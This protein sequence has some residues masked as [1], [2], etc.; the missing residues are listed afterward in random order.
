MI[1][2]LEA[3]IIYQKNG[4]LVVDKPFNIP[5]SGRSLDDDDCLQYWLMQRH[6]TMVWAV[7][8]LDADTSGVNLFVT[9][10]RL[11]SIYKKALEDHNSVKEYLAIVHGNPTWNQCEEFGAIGKIDQ[12]SLGITPDGKSA[13]SQFTVTKKGP[14]HSLVTVNIFT[15]RTHQ[16]RI[17]LSHLGHPIVGEEWYCNP[18]CNR[19]PRQA[20]HCHMVHLPQMEQTFIAPLATD[21]KR[22]ADELQL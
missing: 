19:H 11:V 15:G 14:E 6:G 4:L 18:P 12:R 21:L 16:I 7:H 3:R 13:H 1:D 20:L 17:H 10:K 5:T 22:L 2:D 8:Q 9:E